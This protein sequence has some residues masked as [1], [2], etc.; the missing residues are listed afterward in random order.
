MFTNLDYESSEDYNDMTTNQMNQ[1]VE[2]LSGTKNQPE[3]ADEISEKLTA[4]LETK[5]QENS[6][7]ILLEGGETFKTLVKKQ[8][9]AF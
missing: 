4:P 2:G 9:R 6:N 3:E 1:Y 8:I 5:T 7:A